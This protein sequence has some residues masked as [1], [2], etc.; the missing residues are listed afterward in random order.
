[1]PLP[2]RIQYVSMC[3]G[4]YFLRILHVN[5]SVFAGEQYCDA[6][7]MYQ[8]ILNIYIKAYSI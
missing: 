3:M 1:M 2:G 5:E 8:G 7:N 4:E 6:F